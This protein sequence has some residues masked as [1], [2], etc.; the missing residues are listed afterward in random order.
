MIKVSFQD[1]WMEKKDDI[2]LLSA[3]LVQVLKVGDL[4]FISKGKKNKKI[5]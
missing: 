5:I 4:P 3:D 2:S 1:A